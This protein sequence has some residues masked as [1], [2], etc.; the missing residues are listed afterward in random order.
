MKLAIV[1]DSSAFLT[2]DIRRRVHVLDV[3]ITIDGETFVEG[4]NLTLDDFYSRMA[5]S[6]DL[7]K[8]S[9]PSLAAFDALLSQ[10]VDEGYT[11]VLGLFLSSG[12]SGFFQSI[13]YLLAEYP[14]LTLAIP[15]TKIT[16]APLGSIVASALAW[17][18]KGDDFD[19]I[20]AKLQ[21]QID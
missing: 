20:L 18:D 10:L 5:Q 15:D 16:S 2:D 17:A 14:Q 13:Q 7:P 11:H 8:T 1:T 4:Q 6:S 12:I 3:P 19:T 9:Q 21:Q